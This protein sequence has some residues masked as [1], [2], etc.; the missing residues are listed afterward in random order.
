MYGDLNLPLGKT[1]KEKGMEEKP[2]ATDRL[3]P[4]EQS[5]LSAG[6]RVPRLEARAVAEC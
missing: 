2:C 3:K 4:R 5:D 6:L 1:L